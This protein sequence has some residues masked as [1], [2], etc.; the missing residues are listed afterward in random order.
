MVALL[1]FQ[2]ESHDQGNDRVSAGLCY[3]FV[4]RERV[5]LGAGVARRRFKQPLDR[6]LRH[7]A[8]SNHVLADTKRDTAAST[9]PQRVVVSHPAGR[10]Q[11]CLAMPTPQGW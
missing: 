1:I 2:D 4:L 10:A 3:K 9:T 7:T 6:C 5:L 11:A 8:S